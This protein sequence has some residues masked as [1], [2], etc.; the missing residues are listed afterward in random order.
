MKRSFWITLV[1]V[2]LFLIIILVFSD[3]PSVQEVE[4]R[5]ED[6]P[7]N[8]VS[9]PV[10]RVIDGDT[11]ELESGVIIRLVCIDTPERGELYFDEATA[12]M[13]LLV[14]NKGVR[15]IRDTSDVDRYGRSLRYV[16]TSDGDVGA[17]M[18]SQGLARVYRY[19]PDTARCDDYEELQ[20]QAIRERLGMWAVTGV[21]EAADAFNDSQWESVTEFVTD[22]GHTGI[23][24]VPSKEASV[25]CSDNLFNCDDFKTQA[26]AQAMYDEC[27]WKGDVH[28]LDG[29]DDGVACESLP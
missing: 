2:L 27:D 8:R 6:V 25:A 26:E 20:S 7:L 19:E 14:M 1:A 17:S 13:E 5:I 21:E 16:E 22:E 9:D 10:V 3:S 29:D 18:I 11:V 24:L 15:L 28:G 12:A 23:K 4:E